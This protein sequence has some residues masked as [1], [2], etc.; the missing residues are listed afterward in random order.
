MRFLSSQGP[1]YLSKMAR[2]PLPEKKRGMKQRQKNLIFVLIFFFYQKN[3]ESAWFYLL[4]FLFFF[5]PKIWFFE[6]LSS[7]NSFFG[8]V[9]LFSW[10]RFLEYINYFTAENEKQISW[11][12]FSLYLFYICLSKVRELGYLYSTWPD[13]SII[14]IVIGSFLN[15]EMYWKV[16]L[17]SICTYYLPAPGNRLGSYSFLIWIDNIVCKICLYEL[18]K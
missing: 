8:L 11:L 3:S 9:F 16:F 7:E 13:S 6:K 2:T 10:F 12:S 5:R 1:K 18:S 15:T 4:S 17:V 14:Y